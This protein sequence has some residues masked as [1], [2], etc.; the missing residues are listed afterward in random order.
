MSRQTVVVFLLVISAI[1]VGIYVLIEANLPGSE[2]LSHHTPTPEMAAAPVAPEPRT[3]LNNSS[4]VE[5][6]VTL[7]WDWPAALNANQAFL[8]RV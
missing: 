7:T 5:S 1:S 3:P 4:F 6:D 8:V 2:K